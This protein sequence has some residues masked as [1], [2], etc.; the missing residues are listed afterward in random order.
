MKVKRILA[1]VLT[2]LILLSLVACGAGSGGGGSSGGGGGSSGG[3]GGGAA[4]GQKQPFVAVSFNDLDAVPALMKAQLEKKFEAKGWKYLIAGAD[5]DFNKQ[6]ADI[7][8]MF[9]QGPAVVISRIDARGRPTIAGISMQYPDIPLVA[10]SMGNRRALTKEES[11]AILTASGESE[12]VRGTLLGHWMADYMD[13]NPGFVPKIGFLLGQA[14]GDVVGTGHRSIDFIRIM[15]HRGYIEGKDW[16]A[17]VRAEAD[18]VWTTQGGM[19]IT[20]DWLQKYP[21]EELN[22]IYCWWDEGVVGVCQALELNGKKPGDYIIMSF[23]GLDIVHEYVEKGYVH[24]SSALDFNKQTDK[25]VWI[26]QMVIDGKANE[27]RPVEF[28]ESMYLLT[29]DNLADVKAGNI[30]NYHSYTEQDEVFPP[31]TGKVEWYG[32]NWVE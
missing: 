1:F 14:S 21:I 11:D 30:K 3:G 23:D 20:E 15:E 31:L 8:S 9:L 5:K 26:A 19:K 12:W 25:L 4:G 7:E 2:A 17:V 10:M 6:I 13:A 16:Y 27:L 28:G 24:A 29:K 32:G 22:T 18:P